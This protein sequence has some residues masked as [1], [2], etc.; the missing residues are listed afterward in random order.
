VLALVVVANAAAGWAGSDPTRNYRI[1]AV[2]WYC[3]TAPVGKKCVNAGVYY[4]NKARAKVGLPSY[5][6]PADFPSLKSAQQ[7]FILTNLD[8][9]DYGLPPITGLTDTLSTDAF[10]RGVQTRTDP[11]PSD[12]THV[13]AW[14]ASWAAGYRNAPMAYEAWMWDDGLGS[15]NVECKASDTSGCW[16]HRHNILWD[17]GSTPV[18][19][20]GAA[21][22][23]GPHR[24]RVYATIL[25]GGDADYAPTYSYT[26][27]QAV[28][29]GAGT[30]LYK[31]GRP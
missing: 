1:A 4:L 2:P 10:V 12:T 24:G 20:M 19:A 18:L 13:T 17:F 21:A 6:L 29:D 26:W 22:G 28:A 9:I 7:I 3:V 27:S 25:V 31:P 11:S 5:K 23:L 30:N 15:G 8:R 16:G 14:N